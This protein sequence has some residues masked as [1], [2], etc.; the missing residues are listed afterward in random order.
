ML[1]KDDVNALLYDNVSFVE[2]YDCYVGVEECW[3]VGRLER[4]VWKGC[5]GRISGFRVFENWEGKGVVVGFNVVDDASSSVSS[6]IITKGPSVTDVA[7]TQS[8]RAFYGEAV[9]VRKFVDDGVINCVVWNNNVVCKRG[10]CENIVNEILTYLIKLHFNVPAVLL[11]DGI[12]HLTNNGECFN[13]TVRD[14]QIF[15]SLESIVKD[16]SRDA[17]PLYID[18]VE[19]VDEVLRYTS[20]V[21]PMPNLALLSGS[22]SRS[23][24]KS[25]DNVSDNA[26]DN[27]SDSVRDNKVKKEYG[28]K[29][30]DVMIRFTT[31]NKWPTD[32][33]A[34][35]ASKT[36]MLVSLSKGLAKKE[37]DM[38]CEVGSDGSMIVTYGGYVWKLIIDYSVEIDVLKA[39]PSNTELERLYVSRLEMEGD[40]RIKH[41]NFVKGVMTNVTVASGV[42]RLLDNFLSRHLIHLRIEYVELIVCYVLTEVRKCGSVMSGFV[43]CLRFLSDYDFS[44]N[45]LIVDPNKHITSSDVGSIRSEFYD[46]RNSN[47]NSNSNQKALSI[48]TPYCVE[49]YETAKDGVYNK[50]RSV[51]FGDDVEYIVMNKIKNVCCKSLKKMNGDWNKWRKIFVGSVKGFDIVFNI[52]KHFIVDKACSTSNPVLDVIDNKTPYNVSSASR[53]K[54]IQK[55]RKESFKNLQSRVL[56]QFDP[57]GEFLENVKR[58]Y[59]D[60]CLIWYN[61]LSPEQIGITLRPNVKHEK[62]FATNSCLLAMPSENEGKV[63]FNSED[64]AREVIAIGR[65]VVE[66]YEINY[67]S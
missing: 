59:G 48:V 43:S 2:R 63:V 57:V 33:N 41:H 36:A 52:N 19:C 7:G 32:L 54:G 34:I 21:Q 15:N 42:V 44:E 35:L 6:S 29:P 66:S 65:G 27:A 61:K 22:R 67:S 24:G 40:G 53:N 28:Y 20:Y 45:C 47:S 11:G 8:F 3:D 64:F 49:T 23:S 12:Q 38:I 37:K 30:I 13:K 10:D 58:L 50:Y 39:L 51:A 62:T 16:V 9:E 14:I 18:S 56:L 25:D 4:I 55:L 46:N 60:L 5:Y 17:L 26:S 1:D 31:S